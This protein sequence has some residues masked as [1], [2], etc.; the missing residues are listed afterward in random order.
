M[1]REPAVTWNPYTAGY[2]D[3]PYEHLRQCREENPVHKGVHGAWVIFKYE[4]C[5]NALRTPDAQVSE[6]SEYFREKEPAI[7]KGSGC[8]YLSKGTSKWAM[9]LNGDEHKQVRKVMVKAFKQFDLATILTEAVAEVN[10]L[11]ANKQEFDLVDYCSR[12]IYL[13]I[14]R[15]YSFPDD[16][17]FEEIREYSNMVARSQDLFVPRQV[18]QS[19]NDWFLKGNELFNELS[20]I[21]DPSGYKAQLISLGRETGVEYSEEDILSILSVSVMAAFE[22]SKDSLSMALLEVL[23]S[24]AKIEEIEKASP[25]Q[26][27]VCIEELFRFT[28]PLQYTVRI[29]GSDLQLVDTM[30]PAGSKVFLCLASANR[31][32]LMFE[33][34]DELQLS[35]TVNNHLAFGAGSHAC[36]GTHIA[37]QEMKYCLKPIVEFLKDYQVCNRSEVKY[38][39]QIMMRTIESVWLKKR[40]IA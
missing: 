30:I 24:P 8:P 33:R 14:K 3:N 23:E 16:F 31:D 2:F 36:A 35:R 15:L 26:L 9:Y 20:V 19:I 17:G 11:F 13:V 21:A 7:F 4:D 37:R 5:Y 28:S 38:A 34:P 12:F 6:L 10:S 39:K 27:A 40:T 25:A 1:G 22:T 32:P 18:Y 29:T